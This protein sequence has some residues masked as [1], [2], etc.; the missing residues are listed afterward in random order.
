MRGLRWPVRLERRAPLRWLRGWLGVV[1]LLLAA[2]RRRSHPLFD[3]PFYLERRPDVARSGANP[4]VH[5]LRRGAAE[6]SDPHPLFDAGFYLERNPDV[7]RSGVNPLVHYLGRG[8]AERSDP[9]PLFD[10]R[11]YLATHPEVIDQGFNPLVHFLQHGAAQHSDPHPLFSSEYYL[12]RN[13]DVA[14]AGVN[15]LLHYVRFGAF[16]GRRPHPLFDPTHYGRQC[17]ARWDQTTNP[18]AHYLAC[19]PDEVPDPHPLFDTAYY[20]SLCGREVRETGNPLIHFV[21]KGAR[22]GRAPSLDVSAEVAPPASRARGT[23]PRAARPSSSRPSVD[24][25]AIGPT[26]GPADEWAA[27]VRTRA[28]PARVAI[29]GLGLP[30]R[31][32]ACADAVNALATRTG[33]GHLLL[34]NGSLEPRADWVEPLLRAFEDLPRIGAACASVLADAELPQA[35]VAAPASAGPVRAIEALF[36]GGILIP[37][38]LFLGLGGLDSSAPSL[39]EAIAR[40]SMRLQA[41]GFEVYGHPHSVLVGDESAAWAPTG[42]GGCRALMAILSA[43]LGSDDFGVSDNPAVDA[44]RLCAA[45]GYRVVAWSPASTGGGTCSAARGWQS[46]GIHISLGPGDRVPS[47]FLERGAAEAVLLDGSVDRATLA[48]VMALQ[49]AARLLLLDA[50]PEENASTELLEH[51]DA[52]LPAGA[53]LHTAVQLVVGAVPPVPGAEASAAHDRRVYVLGSSTV[54]AHLEQERQFGDLPLERGVPLSDRERSSALCVVAVD[55]A[56][57]TEIEAVRSALAAGVPV[58]ASPAIEAAAGTGG[59]QTSA[60]TDTTPQ[61]SATLRSLV[62][63]TGLP[64]RWLEGTGAEARRMW[65]WA[66]A[67]R[68]FVRTLR[69]SGLRS[70]ALWSKRLERVASDLAALGKTDADVVFLGM[71][72]WHYRRQRPQ[73]LSAE[74]GRRRRRVIYVEPDFLPASD[75]EPYLVAESPEENVFCVSLRAPRPTDIHRQPPTSGDAAALARSLRALLAAIHATEPPL[76]VHAPF[77]CPV[78]QRLDTSQL[79]YD[80][81][82]LYGAFPNVS[83]E[84]LTLEAQLLRV[85]DLVVFSAA[86]LKDRL[87]VGNRGA[88]VRNGCEYTRFARAPAVRTSDRITV[89]YVGAI[90][91]WFDA[92]LVN[93]CVEACPE[94]QF[95]LAGS[96]A[97]LPAHAF[98][99]RPN[100]VLLGEVEYADVPGLVAGWDVCFIPFADTKLTQSVNPVKVYEYLAAGRPTVATPLPELRMLDPGLVHLA[101]AGREFVDELRAAVAERHDSGLAARRQEWASRQT[102]GVRADEFLNALRA[103]S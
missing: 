55:A 87:P 89:G 69:R 33:G 19:E 96:T 90:D 30:A 44:L 99:P 98:R 26:R 82:D 10:T 83:A 103:Q 9:H 32:P 2:A 25:V 72:P 40:L 34:V 57:A 65:P 88:V 61:L 51:F 38:G 75:P 91:R 73:Q 86:S 97:G 67:Q 92:E 37:R 31:F 60:A 59:I 56:R 50:K 74:L 35:E 71:I 81:M 100:L 78:C 8:A 14:R 12:S 41:A 27:R 16:E 54:V 5:Y 1:E 11:S 68:A 17:R 23:V 22:E 62:A 20:V 13:P 93:R 94:W 85:A 15:P 21:Q 18:L 39:E 45:T 46:L 4:L 47:D 28:A 102:W 77:W 29:A 42:G 43:P 6:R 79:V 70:S 95:V 24:L 66:L 58:H 80:C 53:R 76:V 7:A 101:K 63:G 64:G 84:M 3:V 52:V 36:P 49:P 48:R